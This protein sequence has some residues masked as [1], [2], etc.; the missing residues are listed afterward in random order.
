MNKESMIVR[1]PW[2][3]PALAPDSPTG[4]RFLNPGLAASRPGAQPDAAFITP[5]GLPLGFS[6]A[7]RYVQDAL[8]FGARFQSAGDIAGY[9]ARGDEDYYTHA[10]PKM[11]A[12][13]AELSQLAGGVPAPTKVK[14][15]LDA[16]ATGA[17]AS[18]MTLLLAWTL[19]ERILE[20]AALTEGLASSSAR[21]DA[22]LGLQEEDADEEAAAFAP[23][24]SGADLGETADFAADHAE[25]VA[26]FPWRRSVE[27]MAAFLP[28]DAGLFVCEPFVREAWEGRGAVLELVDPAR[29]KDALP[30]WALAL[31]A[32]GRLWST[33]AP[34]W[35]L[36]D[37][38]R[39][40]E[41][42]PALNRVVTALYC[43]PEV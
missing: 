31:A 14:G 8:E 43:A 40:P 25:A 1:I 23:S 15:E 38:S 22:A 24:S 18:Q 17:L 33:R 41:A 30:E 29:E 36:A 13:L 11:R 35:L 16:K 21:F 26:T 20:L 9:G 7:R 3:H 12:E 28:E 6:Q 5:E 39:Q 4:V 10:D 32:A 2:M 19:E 34:L 42:R 27:H 37:L